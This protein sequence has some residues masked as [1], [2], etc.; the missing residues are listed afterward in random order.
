MPSDRNSPVKFTDGPLDLVRHSGDIETI[1]N[2][3]TQLRLVSGIERGRTAGRL[4]DLR[5]MLAILHAN[6]KTGLKAK[7]ES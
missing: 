5:D 7:G 1:R 2:K 6:V 4:K 3:F